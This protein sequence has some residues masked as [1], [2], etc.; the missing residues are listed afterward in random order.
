MEASFAPIITAR[1][2]AAARGESLEGFG[3]ASL[4]AEAV[5]KKGER[6]WWLKELGVPP[7]VEASTG[8]ASLE[9]RGGVEGAGICSLLPPPPLLLL[10]I[11]VNSA[12]VRPNPFGSV[13]RRAT[14]WSGEGVSDGDAEDLAASMES[15]RE[16]ATRSPLDLL[17]ALG[18]RAIEDDAAAK[19]DSAGV[20]AEIDP[21][22]AYSLGELSLPAP[23]APS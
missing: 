15:R 4:S 17:C 9:T 21:G 12:E 18:R 16:D 7:D 23:L 11:E 6:V 20:E 2:S 14:G 8:E 3:D 10:L 5:R 13:A 22:S 1:D 19:A